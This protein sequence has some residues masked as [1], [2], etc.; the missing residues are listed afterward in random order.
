MLH[1]V[2][3]SKQITIL[4]SHILY[5]RRIISIIL[6]WLCYVQTGIDFSHAFLTQ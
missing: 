4:A 2:V 3:I 1:C 6:Y 5:A